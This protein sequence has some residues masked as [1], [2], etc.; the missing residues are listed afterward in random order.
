MD[1]PGNDKI[2]TSPV[3][4]SQRIGSLDILRGVA[5]LG[6]LTMNI[7]AFAMPGAAYFNPRIYGDLSG[8]NYFVWMTFHVFF[9][10][11]F[12]AI[13]SMLF[14]AGI[15]LMSNRC[16]A[17]GRKP[18]GLHYRRMFW[19]ILFGAIHS[20]LIW[21]GDILLMYGICGLVVYLFRKRSAKLLIPLGLAVIG[22]SSLFSLAVGITFENWP[23]EARAEM[24]KQMHPPKE[25]ID[26]EITAYRGNW[27]EQ[28]SARVPMALELHTGAFVFFLFWRISGLMLLGMAL[29]KTGFFS[30]KLAPRVYLLFVALA[31]IIGIPV[32]LYGISANFAANWKVPDTF[33]VGLQ[34]NYW[35]SL[36]VALGWV[37][38]VMLVVKTK[39]L[40]SLTERLSAVG[41]MAF[42]NYILQSLI[43]TAI[44]YGHGLGYFGSVERM[45]QAAVVVFVWLVILILSPIWLSKFKYGPLEWLW[46]SLAYW[47]R[48][49][50]TR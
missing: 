2:A 11:K 10:L 44:F 45:G 39:I 24:I 31:V 26:K 37:G 21:W 32:I 23:P 12:M 47:H 42:S 4:E 34:F 43:C 16:E 18:A 7:S 46:R 29:F 19:L 35:A 50:F 5:V 8:V 14:G 49:P 40:K 17:S 36:L 27:L 3:G 33:F 6:I 38:V 28:M 13:F 22:V 9:D 41:R 30:A 20:Y 15:V 1:D 48:Q 25:V